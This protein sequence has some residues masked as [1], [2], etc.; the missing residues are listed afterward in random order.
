LKRCVTLPYLSSEKGYGFRII[1][2]NAVGL[3][4]SEVSL[5]KKEL[6]VGDQILEIGG[7]NAIQMSYCEVLDIISRAKDKIQLKVMQNKASKL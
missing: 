5:E 6:Q 3:F 7:E 4:V 2:G 1:G